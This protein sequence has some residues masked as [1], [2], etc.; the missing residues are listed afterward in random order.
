MI[1]KRYYI[2][3]K[4][5][6]VEYVGEFENFSEAWDYINVEQNLNFVWLFKEENMLKLAERIT[7]TFNLNTSY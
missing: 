6:T 3:T 4:N 2:L 5:V 7:E 1:M